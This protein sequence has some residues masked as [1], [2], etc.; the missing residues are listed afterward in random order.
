MCARLSVALLLMG[1]VSFP[2]DTSQTLHERY[3]QPILETYLVRPGIRAAA[4]YGT[5]QHV[6]AITLYPEHPKHPLNL[7]ENSIGAD[8]QVAEVLNELVPEKERGKH[9][10]DTFLNLTCFGPDLD[11]DCGGVEENWEKLTIHRMGNTNSLH[12]AAIHWKRD[13][14][15]DAYADV[16]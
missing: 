7:R 12:Y 10:M 6:C 14:C 2:A 11:V 16:Q 13:E 3:G 8:K 4:R 9:L 15:K 5:S 1:L